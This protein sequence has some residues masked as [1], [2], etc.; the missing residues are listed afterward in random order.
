MAP[1][2]TT[3]AGMV[4]VPHGPRRGAPWDHAL[5][6][7]RQRWIDPSEVGMIEESMQ[8]SPSYPWAARVGI[9]R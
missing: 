6:D 9:E 2:V 1:P 5:A 4:P 7:D 8:Y 3:A